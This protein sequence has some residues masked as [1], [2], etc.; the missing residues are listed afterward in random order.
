[1]TKLKTILGAG[2]LAAA[3]VAGIAAAGVTAEQ[4]ARL[5]ADLTPMGAE[6]AGN[7]AGTIPAWTGGIKSAADA[8]APGFKPGGHHPDPYGND[9]PLYKIDASNMS[10]YAAQLTAGHKALLGPMG[11]G[12]LVVR[13]GVDV[14]AWR[15]GGTG[16]DSSSPV[17]PEGYPYYL[18]GGTPNAVGLAGLGAGARWVLE[19]GPAAIGAHER[20]LA[21]RFATALAA[22]AKIT[23]AACPAEGMPDSAADG[24]PV[25]SDIG[26]VSFTV[27]GYQ[28]AE[29]AAVLDETFGIAMRAGLHCAPYVH[30]RRG[31]FPGGTVRASAGPFTTPAEI[32]EAAAAVLEI[33]KS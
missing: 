22:S 19:K 13:E 6:K 20:G 15:E 5:G 32:D 17:Q 28:P 3:G 8:G 26:L 7:A 1:M 30:R 2:V 23:I 9:K 31:L 18:E 21:A 14:A 27:A 33:A 4:A 10:K 12:G 16:G 25:R 11:T 24:S 29:V